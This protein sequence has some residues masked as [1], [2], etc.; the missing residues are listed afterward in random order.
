[1]II[2]EKDITEFID[3]HLY[4]RPAGNIIRFL[5]FQ[6]DEFINK[7]RKEQEELDKINEGLKEWNLD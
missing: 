7:Q 2:D 5:P 6:W 3:S 1:M 4:I